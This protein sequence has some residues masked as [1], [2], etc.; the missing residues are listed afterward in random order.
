MLSVTGGFLFLAD[1]SRAFRQANTPGHACTRRPE[2]VKS[3]Q[4][5][6]GAPTGPSLC[7]FLAITTD[8]ENSLL[9][10]S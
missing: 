1:D 7:H 5:L 3:T 6:F 9:S 8:A 4:R 10:G 2:P